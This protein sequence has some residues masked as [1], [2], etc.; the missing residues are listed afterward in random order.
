[1]FAR[2]NFTRLF[3]YILIT[4]KL[5]L[6][7]SESFATFDSSGRLSQVEMAFKAVENFGGTVIAAQCSD[8]AILVTWSVMNDRFIVPSSKFR[9]L[10]ESI[11]FC[12]SG[13]S[14]DANYIANEMFQESLKHRN[15]FGSEPVPGRLS[16][17]V[18]DFMHDNTLSSRMR[19]LAIKCLI[20]GVQS[21]RP[22]IHE[23]DPMGNLKK[24]SLTTIGLH[25]KQI[26]SKWDESLD[27]SNFKASELLKK[28]LQCLEAG[29][30]EEDACEKKKEKI[31]SRSI[32][33]AVV[34][35]NIPFREISSDAI[36]QVV[37]HDDY[38][39]FEKEIS[40]QN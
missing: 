3:F 9:K 18:A 37:D 12:A 13:I 27:P 28:C 11:G 38:T 4:S 6:S 39:Y 19:P 5:I 26:R 23:I 31:N 7:H 2:M 40:K 35:P 16:K 14:A 8:A 34:G 36:T 17:F 30:V 21:N 32:Q 33:I 20:A 10:G 25:S 15:L 24:C 29:I 1:M 22:V